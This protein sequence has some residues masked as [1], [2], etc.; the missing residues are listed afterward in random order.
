M[1]GQM[2]YPYD[3][4]PLSPVVG[5]PF[6]NTYSGL[7]SPINATAMSL[8]STL[9][10]GGGGVPNR[11]A[12]FSPAA[13]TRGG[14]HAASA[15][16][17][18]A[19]TLGGGA[20]VRSAQD[21]Y[22]AAPVDA[23]QPPMWRGDCDSMTLNPGALESTIFDLKH[24]IATQNQVFTSSVER[25][26]A[27]SVRQGQRFASLRI[28]AAWVVRLCHSRSLARRH[29][30]KWQRWKHYRLWAKEAH[31]KRVRIGAAAPSKPAEAG[32]RASMIPLSPQPSDLFPEDSV[33]PDVLRRRLVEARGRA[34]A[35]KQVC[36]KIEGDLAAVT[37][38]NEELREKLKAYE[39]GHLLPLAPDTTPFHSVFGNQPMN[40]PSIPFGTQY[41]AGHYVTV[42]TPT[43]NDPSLDRTRT[44]TDPTTA[45]HDVAAAWAVAEKLHNAM[46]G[47]GTDE[48]AIYVALRDVRSQ[49]EWSGV[50]RQF[51]DQFSNFKSG[52][53]RSA[54]AADLTTREL[55]KCKAILE[56][57]GVQYY[58]P[59][60]QDRLSPRQKRREERLTRLSSPRNARKKTPVKKGP[61][62]GASGARR[63]SPARAKPKPSQNLENRT[64]EARKSSLVQ[65]PSQFRPSVS[66]D[67][68]RVRVVSPTGG[69]MLKLPSAEMATSDGVSKFSP[70]SITRVSSTIV[71]TPKGSPRGTPQGSPRGSPRVSPRDRDS[72]FAF[73]E[74]P[75]SPIRGLDSKAS[76]SNSQDFI[77]YEDCD[78]D[79][80]SFKLNPGGIV[81][82][83]NGEE[84]PPSKVIVISDNERR[85]DFPDIAKAVM[86]PADD[87]TKQAV[88]SAL[89]RIALK[90]S[91]GHNI[92]DT[93]VFT[94][95]SPSTSRL[96]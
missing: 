13:A 58:D 71:A 90:G 39:Q 44:F 29:Y 1:L 24:E 64:L 77:Q 52:N 76:A 26:K 9:G 50:I 57:N 4:E 6:Q 10:G 69:T 28:K 15:A 63:K 5:R 81:Y 92:P 35:L 55:D 17:L 88:L 56:A 25:H 85:V 96:M 78:G 74:P 23:G 54:L 38:E 48:E 80:L 47:Y 89:R 94:H 19:S 14:A 93:P 43:T 51:K 79:V 16:Q 70:R 40:M 20:R 41:A 65:H 31:P 53:L 72:V 60:R 8:S 86:L 95:A 7:L 68:G 49:A 22:M 82:S 11:G 84:R 87:A 45:T 36:K 75:G 83:V 59:S 32:K 73:A 27:W 30:D 2:G 12:P 3:G 18:P 66:S 42:Q 34:S 61:D 62:P 46:K 33:S 37:G 91:V 21:V 67:P